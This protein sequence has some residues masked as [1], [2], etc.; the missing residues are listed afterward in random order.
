MTP[1]A[2]YVCWCDGDPT[3][4]FRAETEYGLCRE[5]SKLG[6]RPLPPLPF[7]LAP[8]DSSVTS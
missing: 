4:G 6:H 8:N 3:C 1:I 2:D 5:C 7:S